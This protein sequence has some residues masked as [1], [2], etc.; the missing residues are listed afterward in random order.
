MS[1][2]VFYFQ[3][4]LLLLLFSFVASFLLS[5]FHEMSETDSGYALLRRL[6]PRRQAIS[7]GLFSHQALPFHRAQ[8]AAFGSC[9]GDEKCVRSLWFDF[10]RFEGECSVWLVLIVKGVR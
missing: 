2:A 7:C 3:V 1:H 8:G 9:P 5:L 6:A 10:T 4:L